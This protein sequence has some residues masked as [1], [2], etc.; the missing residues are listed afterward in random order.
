M[1]W[2]FVV[3]IVLLFNCFILLFLICCGFAFWFG[4]MLC[5]YCAIWWVI[6]VVCLTVVGVLVFDCCG[7][8][9]L[10]FDWF[11]LVFDS[12]LVLLVGL[13]VCVWTDLF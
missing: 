6:L 2:F 5:W 9:D 11:A 7:F 4:L 8:G 13:F 12:C 3:L 1:F 10:V